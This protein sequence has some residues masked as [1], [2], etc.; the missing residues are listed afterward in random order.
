MKP[1]IL[2]S[3]YG[4]IEQV[5]LVQPGFVNAY[6]G[7]ALEAVRATFQQYGIACII[8]KNEHD[9]W[10]LLPGGKRGNLPFDDPLIAEL[11]ERGRGKDIEISIKFDLRQWSEDFFI[12][13]DRDAAFVQSEWAQDGFVVLQYD[14]VH[15]ILLQPLI[16]RRFMDQFNSFELSMERSLAF[17]LRPT[18]LELEG[19]NIL[20]GDDFALIGKNTLARNWDRRLRRCSAAE[21]KD[22]DFLELAL[23]QLAHDVADELGVGEV[24]WVGFPG[25][26]LDLFCEGR[27]TFQSDFHIDLYLT[28][29]GKTETGRELLFVADP[30]LG[31]RIVEERTGVTV[32]HGLSWEG[33]SIVDD[34]VFDSFTEHLEEF[35]SNYNEDKQERKFEVVRLPMLIADGV[36]YSY[37]NCLVEVVGAKR[38]VFLPNYVEHDPDDLK[39]SA[40]KAALNANLSALNS[41]VEAIFKAHDFDEIVWTGR[42]AHFIHFASRRGSLHCL[43]KVLRR[44]DKVPPKS[45]G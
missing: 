11:L 34:L 12:L 24:I 4:K 42:G 45:I 30:G 39:R 18:M 10:E 9:V 44:L 43:T 8:L 25:V 35:F 20:V 15:N 41:V 29:G 33:E 5:L 31:K 14:D 40:K 19:G 1:R 28:L 37:N 2:S 13:Q 36:A 17:L 6:S 38:R 3:V 23:K 32:Q 27:L 22:H 16:S 7:K 26:R 21:L